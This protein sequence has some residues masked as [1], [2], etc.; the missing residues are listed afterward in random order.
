MKREG[1]KEVIVRATGD[2]YDLHSVVKRNEASEYKEGTIVVKNPFY[3]PKAA[4]E[5]LYFDPKE[6]EVIEQEKNTTAWF[7]QQK[8]KQAISGTQSQERN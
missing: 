7:E 8:S 5:W 4:K 6:V 1:K 3:N 2:K